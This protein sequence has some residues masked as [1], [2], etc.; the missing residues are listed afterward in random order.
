MPY[1][2]PQYALRQIK[3]G[4]RL[5]RAEDRK[6]SRSPAHAG[7]DHGVRCGCCPRCRAFVRIAAAPRGHTLPCPNC[8]Q[9]IGFLKPLDDDLPPLE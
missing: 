4:I 9:L 2:D 7:H 1:W 5:P 8:G 3:A 6:A